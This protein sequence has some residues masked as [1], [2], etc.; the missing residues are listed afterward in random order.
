MTYFFFHIPKTGGTSF[1]RVLEQWFKTRRDDD[2]TPEELRSL[3]EAPSADLCI[4]GHFSGI[5]LSRG[6][7]L[8]ARYP[9]IVNN[10]E[11]PVFTFFRD[12]VEQAVSYYYHE[13]DAGR[14]ALPLV[15]FL[16]TPHTYSLSRVLEVS[17]QQELEAA[18]RSF[19]F[20]GVTDELQRSADRMADLLNKPRMEVPR[21]RVG[22]RDSQVLDLSPAG[23][24]AVENLYPL[25]CEL[26]ARARDAL[27]DR[28]PVAW[29]PEDQFTYLRNRYS[30][31]ARV[32][33]PS[34]A[35]AVAEIVSFKAHGRDDESRGKFDCREAIGLTVEF[36]V[37]DDTKIVEPAIRVTRQGHPVFVVAYVP[38]PGAPAT[39]SRGRH[40][41]T[42]WIPGNL[43]NTGP[44]EVFSNLATPYPV[45]RFDHTT[46]PVVLEVVEPASAEDTARGSWRTPFPGG[47]RPLL[48][49]TSS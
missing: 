39:F 44:F 9:W 19:L 12:P 29:N 38:E 1:K 22:N 48:K 5:L 17:T 6:D 18:L 13:R 20:I 15:D 23:R 42:T 35:K 25:E 28:R 43:L 11:A 37:H 24:R 26:Y 49:W 34:G 27:F 3:A 16:K 7:S 30:V 31:K 45:E 4:H 32:G 46:E 33:S 8:L 14:A 40:R 41:V 36:D 2:V 10:R 47:V 21:H